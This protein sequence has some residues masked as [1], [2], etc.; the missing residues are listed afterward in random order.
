[1][2]TNI[3][4]LRY[5]LHNLTDH[6]AVTI[7]NQQMNGQAKKEIRA[8]AQ[9]MLVIVL[10]ALS[11]IL[12][13]LCIRKGW[14]GW[15]I[16]V[17][18]VFAA[19]SL[20]LHITGLLNEKLRIY[21][22]S[23]FL[24]FQLFYYVS[25][26]GT[27]LNCTPIV[28]FIML[29][30]LMTGEKKLVWLAAFTS[31]AGMVLGLFSPTAIGRLIW[32]I[33]VI[34]ASGHI[35]MRLMDAVRKEE[36]E[37]NSKIEA[38]NQEAKSA[39]DFLTNVSH[40]IR[41]PVNVV[42]GLSGVCL[43]REKDEEI[44]DNLRSISEAGRRVA[45]Q[46]N[47][48][49]DYSEIEMNRLVVNEE[50]F[51]F[52]SLINDLVNELK[53]HTNKDIELVIDV[54]PSLPYIMKTDPVKL[55]RILW[56]VIVNA[57]KYT[58]EGGVYVHVSSTPQSYGINL[59]MDVTD[60]GIGMTKE[61]LERVYEHFYQSDSGR[62]RT[63]S[64]LGLGMSVALGLVDALK[65]FI[66]LESSLES[67]TEVHICIPVKVVDDRWCLSVREPE[68][69]VVA[70]CLHFEKFSN[71]SVRDFYNN[72]V[73]NS[74]RGLKITVHRV[75]NVEELKILA[76]NLRMTHVVLSE[77]A[78]ISDPEYMAELSKKATI[79]VI[80]RF[81]LRTEYAPGVRLLE[82][83]FY[84]VPVVSILNEET[85]R[86]ED[87]ALL[88]YEGV[89]ALVVDDE[90]MNLT[91]AD[92]ILGRYGIEVIPARSGQEAIDLCSDSQF[93]IIFMDHMM[94]GMDGIEAAK[95]IRNLNS[96]GK[97]IPIVALTANA[98]SSAEDMFMKE[99]FDGFISKPIELS[100]L[101]RVLRKVL[102]EQISGIQG[103]P[104][105]NASET[106]DIPDDSFSTL[107]RAGIEPDKGLELCINDLELYISLMA[108]FVND[109][110]LKQEELERFFREKDW[111]NFTVRIHA[112]KSSSKMIGAME[113]SESARLLEEASKKKDEDFLTEG[114]KD[115]MPGF[116]KTVE[117]I[118]EAYGD[119]LLDYLEEEDI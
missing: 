76:E 1:M 5:G 51:M 104:G 52:P 102:P 40:E 78:Y 49:L 42:L 9:V 112:V 67:G 16:P 113:L 92:S 54:E 6:T 13:S 29:V 86:A 95:R 23:F 89:R 64:G 62:T 37:L 106:E 18:C 94:P 105:L 50:E 68:R 22:Y 19:G 99:G 109:A 93:D 25:N 33:V 82:K 36:E 39:D 81:G 60:T 59:C 88:Y 21:L 30:L 97:K 87:K 63:E 72:M 3:K 12:I 20:F 44:K 71:P 48:I 26:I 45:E 35:M 90:P 55:K 56:H 47:D 61:E 11:V 77:E 46:I 70:A 15:V 115:F 34:L 41:T 32:H 83:P 103:S 114:F 110:P 73:K 43:D 53:I 24:Y 66:K 75:D 57:L 2:H 28:I 119:T 27:V 65:G 111:E 85:P 7:R 38:L 69:L 107:I 17:F 58:R 98:V 74:V 4:K 79:M 31:I 118:K 96:G 101:E 80:N 10:T 100:R 91:V 14:D 8:L 84:S 108:E 117:A 116:L